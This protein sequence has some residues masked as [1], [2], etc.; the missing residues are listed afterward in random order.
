MRWQCK[1]PSWTPSNFFFCFVEIDFVC[2]LGALG[3]SLILL[4]SSP[5]ILCLISFSVLPLSQPYIFY[6]L[7]KQ[8][9]G[10]LLFPL[11]SEFLFFPTFFFSF[12]FS[13]IWIFFPFWNRSRTLQCYNSLE[14]TLC[15]VFSHFFPFVHME[16]L[17]EGIIACRSEGN[18][19]YPILLTLCCTCCN[20]S[21]S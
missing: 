2:S 15:E 11:Q 21:F 17:L 5:L 8:T 12:I 20:G 18:W 9:S 14:F 7:H 1:V 10:S 6:F 3:T 19:N 16:E 4:L 13:F